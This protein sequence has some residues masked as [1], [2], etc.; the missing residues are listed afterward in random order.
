LG[1]PEREIAENAI[2]GRKTGAETARLY[3]VSTPTASRIVA[4]Q[5]ARLTYD[6][7]QI[8]Q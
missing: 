4:A 3:N 5:R 2:S 8:V 1:S 7:E 6:F